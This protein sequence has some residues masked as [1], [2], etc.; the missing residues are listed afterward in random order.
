MQVIHETVDPFNGLYYDNTRGSC[1]FDPYSLVRQCSP[2]SADKRKRIT[3]EPSGSDFNLGV[4]IKSVGVR[5]FHPGGFVI[6]RPSGIGDYTFVQW[7]TPTIVKIDGKTLQERPG[8]CIVYRPRD[9]QWYGSDIF[10]PF[11]NNWFHF[12]GEKALALLEESRIPINSPAY[13]RDDSIVESYLRLFLRESMTKR[14]GW[15]TV[16]S[17]YASVFFIEMGRNIRAETGNPMS[18]RNLE[19]LEKFEQFREK[20]RERCAEHWT[21]N[22][23]AGELHLSASRFSKLYRDFFDAKPVDD[24]IHM[25]IALAEYYLQNTNLPIN[26]ISASCGFSD[27]YYFSRLFKARTGKTA[28]S[29]RMAL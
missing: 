1:F 23:M 3:V 21:L 13:L 16:A 25:R 17:S 4:E 10:T 11:G 14:S 26:Y 27:T 29:F 24:L 12:S 15:K 6:D 22:R 9:P 5:W 18:A 28:S 20:L 2:A 7:L 8:G 19:L